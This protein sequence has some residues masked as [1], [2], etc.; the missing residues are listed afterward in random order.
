MAPGK[1]LEDIV[2]AILFIRM[3][4]SIRLTTKGRGC[5]PVGKTRTSPGVQNPCPFG[6]ETYKELGAETRPLTMLY[7]LPRRGH[8]G[9]TGDSYEACPEAAAW[10]MADKSPLRE[11]RW[12]SFALWRPWGRRHTG[13]LCTDLVSGR[14]C[15]STNVGLLSNRRSIL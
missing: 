6:M 9:D 7:H 8:L 5:L 10:G 2:C 12:Q 15:V 1:S 3:L 11:G 14:A 13:D 4:S